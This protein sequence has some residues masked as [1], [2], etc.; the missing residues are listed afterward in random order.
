MRCSPVSPGTLRKACIDALS[1][2]RSMHGKRV[3]SLW[4]RTTS[5]RS[6]TPEQSI[7]RD[8]PSKAYPRRRSSSIGVNRRGPTKS[9]RSTARPSLTFR[10]RSP[11]QSASFA[12]SRCSSAA[13]LV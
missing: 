3:E 10:V 12:R 2:Y 13:G 11:R 5:G 4:G 7:E 8:H 1:G 9:V 6:T